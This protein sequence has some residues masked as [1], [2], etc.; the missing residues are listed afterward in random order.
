MISST[1]IMRKSALLLLVLFFLRTM[2]AS[3]LQA[4]SVT[5]SGGS[6]RSLSAIILRSCYSRYD[7]SSHN[8]SPFLWIIRTA[9]MVS[10]KRITDIVLPSQ[11]RVLLINTR[12]DPRSQHVLHGGPVCS[13]T[14]ILTRRSPVDLR[15][16]ARPPRITMIRRFHR[17]TIHLSKDL[18]I[19]MSSKVFPPQAAAFL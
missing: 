12:M 5:V 7:Y 6:C 3:R 4:D 1:L 18:D 17:T 19:R 9:S 10:W 16:S 13:R 2:K 15:S 14:G 8:H 11:L